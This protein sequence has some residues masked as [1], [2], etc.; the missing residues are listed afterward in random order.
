[1]AAI[2]DRRETLSLD[3]GEF[4]LAMNASE[5]GEGRGEVMRPS[6]P[7]APVHTPFDAQPWVCSNG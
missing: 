3:E 5:G 1:M 4:F 6:P 2:S 7:P